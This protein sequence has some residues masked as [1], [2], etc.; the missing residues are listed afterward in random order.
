MDVL[1]ALC[2]SAFLYFPE[3]ALL[4]FCLLVVVDTFPACFSMR[5]RFGFLKRGDAEIAEEVG[6]CALRSLRLCISI[7]SC[8]RAAA[9]H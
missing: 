9:L 3:C 4:R 5:I 6:G 1:R 8:M 7:F 2:V